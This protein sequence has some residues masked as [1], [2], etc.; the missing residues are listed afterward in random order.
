MAK[1]DYNKISKIDLE[2]DVLSVYENNKKEFNRDFYLL[3][4]RFSRAP[5]NRLFGSWNKMLKELNIPIVCS[6]MDATKEELISDAKYLNEKF[7]FLNATLY[8]ENGK[9]SQTIVDRLFGSH[10]EF[11]RECGLKSSRR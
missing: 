4:G 6:R 8:R 9:F 7:G 10:I 3:N 2:L 5:I 1:G 11:M